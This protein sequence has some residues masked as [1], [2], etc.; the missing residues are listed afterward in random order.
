MESYY[1]VPRDRV[2]DEQGVFLD[3]RSIWTAIQLHARC[4]QT[5]E[6]EGADLANLTAREALRVAAAAFWGLG[7][8]RA[9]VFPDLAAAEPAMREQLADLDAD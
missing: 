3:P 6:R 2:I 7:L 8:D 4:L 9:R 1:D 5:L